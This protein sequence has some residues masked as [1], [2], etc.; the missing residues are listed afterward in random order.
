[1]TKS[2]R[3]D[4]K[5]M[6]DWNDHVDH[7]LVGEEELRTIIKDL[8]HK[9]DTDYSSE[10]KNP[11]LVGVLKGSVTFMT[12][13][14]RAVSIPAQIDFMKVSSYGNSTVASGNVNIILDLN[15]ADL[16]NEDIILV[17][18]IVDSGRTL[19]YLVAYLLSKG[20]RSV[21]TVTLLDKPERREVDF[22]PEYIGKTIPNEF[23]IGYGLDYAE[24][25]RT[26]PYV[27][28]IRDDKI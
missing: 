4:I 24:K 20:A 22:T 23:V 16:P 10:D 8:A 12:D 28:V 1:M 19:K 11:V 15:R 5:K 21:R 7:V 3:K 17:E 25:Y 26:L 6:I 2:P 13:L 27:G 18:D 14:M 9:I